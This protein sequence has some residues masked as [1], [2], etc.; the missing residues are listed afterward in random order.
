MK[1]KLFFVIA[2][3]SFALPSIAT[4]T[5]PPAN[6]V[7]NCASCHG[8]DGAGHT[9]LGRMSRAV[10]LTDG[11]VQ[12]SFTD[13]QAFDTI[14]NGRVVNGT[15]KMKPFKDKLSDDEIKALVSYLRTLSK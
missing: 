2:T 8:S 6:W 11:Q 12:K 5:E 3:F 13:D 4:T 9:R 7:K 1:T 10:D 14:K 15:T